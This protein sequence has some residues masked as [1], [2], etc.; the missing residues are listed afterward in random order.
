MKRIKSIYH[1][2][3]FFLVMIIISF[4]ILFQ[5]SAS[6]LK[7][8]LLHVAQ[9][10]MNY[11]KELLEQKINEIE[12]EADGILNSNDLK[13]LQIVLTEDRDI[14]D[15]VM[16]VKNIKDYLKT[17]QKSNVGMAEF[18]LYWPGLEHL[19]TTG[20]QS[21][22][23]KGILARTADHKWFYYQKEAYYVRKYAEDWMRP[24]EEAFLIIRM[25]KDFLYQLKNNASAMGTGGSMLLSDGS[26]LFPCS[27]IEKQILDKRK[28]YEDALE[29]EQSIG[30]KQVQ[31]IRSGNVCNGMEIAAYY[32]I[33][34][35]QKPVQ[36]M[37]RITVLL[38]G[39]I[40]AVG[41]VFMILYYKNIL[42]QLTILTEKLRRVENGDLSTRIRELPDN[43]FAYVFECFNEMAARTEEL[44]QS[45]V[46]EQK[47]R[48]Q[49]E[50]K[51]LQMQIHPHFL[52]NSLSY[53]V[54]V[55]DKPEAVTQMAV[56]LASYYR[57]AT[58]HR[59]ITSIGEE[60]DYA[61]AYLSIMA[62]RKRIQYSINVSEEL[63]G[64]P[65][66]PLIL[67]P[68]IENAVEHG[69]EEREYAQHIHLKIYR[70]PNESVRFE[71]SDD[72]NGLTEEEIARLME[73]LGKKERD[74]EESVGL[75]NVNQRLVNY[76]DRYAGLRFGR[77]I[78]GGL[79]VSFTLMPKRIENETSDRG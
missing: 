7:K 47:L 57:Y 4:L 2:F 16:N 12:I 62:M 74:G 53:I 17:R 33:R 30:G 8:S 27:G 72:G 28:L 19:V 23:D 25:D 40:L 15:Y 49:V 51:Q 67:Q 42:L 64:Q 11:A 63:S 3:A 37:M 6:I 79:S 78:W 22:I 10:Q 46:K 9:I 34:Q 58:R 20:I 66:I 1:I 18:I 38:L 44:L 60:V 59:E 13:E 50:L 43:E 31:I 21:Q 75:W 26:S 45:T 39:V 32:P 70:L 73:R 41:F 71:I 65:I 55:A 61:R 35:I 68:I 77:S 48:G 76:Y 5:Y 69:I 54:T 52:Y 24:G 36:H 29:Y 14:Y 56:H